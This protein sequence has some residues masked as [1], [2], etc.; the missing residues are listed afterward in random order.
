V[1]QLF[2]IPAYNEAEILPSLITEIRTK[3]PDFDYVI[4]NDGSTDRTRELCAEQNYNAIHLIANLGIGGAVQA[5]YKYALENGY[6]LAVQLA[7]DGQHDPAWVQSLLPPILD[8][9]A[10]FVIGS[11][12]IDRQG[13]QTTWSRRT[14]IGWL[15]FIL[16]VITHHIFTDATSG[17]RAANRQVIQ[18]FAASYPFDYPEPETICVAVRKGFKVREVPVVMRERTTGRSSIRPF[19]AVYY[20]LKVTLA[21]LIANI[22]RI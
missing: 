9:R 6:D 14:G 13:F 8:E 5:G 17:F 16:R 21:I 10:D 22:K 7:G 2:I 4:V 19:N 1:K 18:L 12:F 15:N 11:R 20:V 3:A